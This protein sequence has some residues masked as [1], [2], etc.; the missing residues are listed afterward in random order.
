MREYYPTRTLGC[1]PIHEVRNWMYV[2]QI[3]RAAL[4]GETIN[5]ILIEGPIGNGN[6]L[7][8]THRAAANDL[9]DMLGKDARVPVVDLNDI[10]DDVPEELLDAIEAGDYE[11]IDAIW[12]VDKL[13]LRFV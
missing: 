3:M 12:D 5:P 6:L 2:R 1:N 13:G 4:A 9:L 11:T 10:I 7:A 8:G